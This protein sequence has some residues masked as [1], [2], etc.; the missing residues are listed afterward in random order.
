MN[1]KVCSIFRN[2]SAYVGRYA[3]QAFSLQKLLQLR[4]HNVSFLL[5]HGDSTD[6]T[7]DLLKSYFKN[8]PITLV[9]VSHGGPDHGSVVNA[10]RFRQLSIAGNKIWSQLPEEADIV[11]WV[12]ADLV[13]DPLTLVS[14]AE[15]ATF[16]PMVA[17][18]I[19]LH[20][21][22]WPEDTFYDTW[23]FVRD[24]RNFVHAPPYHPAVDSET[25][26]LEMDSVGSCFAIWG[27]LARQLTIP[28]EDV[29]VGFCRMLREDLGE[30]IW[31]DTRLSVFHT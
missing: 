16:L 23:A 5:G 27:E 19:I 2:S 1:I 10:Q 8:S 7:P 25:D 11:I 4:G 22:G 18:K 20:R 21:T 24:G 3:L 17:P 13:W 9:D 15:S 6:G 28:S 12:E 29:L 31:L 14:L 30:Q 26:L